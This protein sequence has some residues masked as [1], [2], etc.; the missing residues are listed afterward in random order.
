MRPALRKLTFHTCISGVIEYQR[1]ARS[2][3]AID[4]VSI[5]P[6]SLETRLSIPPFKLIWQDVGLCFVPLQYTFYD[7]LA[8]P[9]LNSLAVQHT[10]TPKGEHECLSVVCRGSCC[11]CIWESRLEEQ[12]A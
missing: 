5:S 11:Q 1:L 6:V 10:T 7:A 2:Y 8:G 9:M 12:D 4:K 3:S